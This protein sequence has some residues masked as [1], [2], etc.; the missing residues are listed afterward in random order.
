MRQ[1]RSDNIFS[2]TGC[3]GKGLTSNRAE[4]S[5]VFRGTRRCVETGV[6]ESFRNSAWST[7]GQ[8]P[9]PE[10]FEGCISPRMHWSREDYPFGHCP[11]AINAG[12]SDSGMK[13]HGYASDSSSSSSKALYNKGLRP[14]RRQDGGTC[15]TNGLLLDRCSL[16]RH[17]R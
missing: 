15:L 14:K 3:A 8:R 12:A 6:Q 9:A 7:P 16:S 1:S 4:L 5:C 17:H 10:F 13:P 11:L 2:P